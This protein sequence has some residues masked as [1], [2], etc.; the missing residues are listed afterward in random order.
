MPDPHQRSGPNPP[1]T[2]SP[3]PPR[4][5]LPPNIFTDDVIFGRFGLRAGWGILLFCFLYLFAYASIPVL[6]EPFQLR[7]ET[8]ATQSQT[9]Q[10]QTTP[11]QTTPSATVPAAEAARHGI[12]APIYL[13]NGGL[14]FAA[15][16]FSSWLLSRIEQRRVGVFGIASRRLR[17]FLPGAFW[18]LTSM[19]LL[20]AALHAAHLLVFDARA[21]T[22]PAI[23][24]SGAIWI[25]T[26]LAVGL[27]E[28]YL[29]RGYLLFTLTRGLYGLAEWLTPASP[30]TRAIAFWIAAVLMS[31][32]FGALHL[33]NPGETAPG[34]IAVFLAGMVFS[35][36]LWRTGSLWWAIGFHMTWDWAQSFL[37]G[38]PDSGALSAG[39]LFVTHPTGRPL[40]SGG[41]D[42]PEGSLLVLPVF[43]LVALIIR[44]TTHKGA[45]PS[46]EP[47]LSLGSQRS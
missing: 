37:Y 43:L 38:V 21:L 10:S 13:L 12:H 26:F 5:T 46:L 9:T 27:G 30:R 32:V 18:G 14:F 36:A 16:L 41:V 34:I 29:F 2:E 25:A 39:R 3:E 15:L 45:Q 44:T 40:L 17:D 1:A 33:R 35:Y 31:C 7:F 4:R 20:I 19:S 28:E 24:T 47:Q 6:T 8:S 23:F 11:S 42:G 22:G